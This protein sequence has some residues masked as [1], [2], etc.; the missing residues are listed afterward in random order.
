MPKRSAIAIT[1]LLLAIP[2]TSK[3]KKKPSLPAAILRAQY[4]A[5]VVDPDAGIPVM[6]PG[7]NETA[8]SDVEAALQKWGRFKTTLNT[9]TPDLIFVV[10]KG[11]KPIKPTIG[12][13]PNEPPVVVNPVD[14]GITIRGR[15][16]TPPDLSESGTNRN[17]TPT[18]RSEVSSPDDV[19][20]VYLGGV[21]YPLD[22]PPLWRYMAH[23]GLQHPTVPAVEK[24]RQA[25]ADS[26]KAKP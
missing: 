23:N 3:D 19:L 15:R 26:E 25:I 24:L 12:G 16:G 17:G 8:R 21:D 18:M 20:A 13:V 10:R 2:S 1:I 9:T 4:V 22:S 14:S 11:G 6:S 5:V 7:E